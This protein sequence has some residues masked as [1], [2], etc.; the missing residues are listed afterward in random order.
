MKHIKLF[1]DTT[2]GRWSTITNYLSIEADNTPKQV[3]FLK[4]K[5]D[6]GEPD[7]K[8]IN[9]DFILRGAEGLLHDMVACGLDSSR[10]GGAIKEAIIALKPALR[11]TQEIQ[12]KIQSKIQSP[13]PPR[14]PLG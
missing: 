13:S 9:A 14:T 4:R 3:A 10:Y 1:E 6:Q 12:S 5:D 7:T 11:K 8:M 2:Q